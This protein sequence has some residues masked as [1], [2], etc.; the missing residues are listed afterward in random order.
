[1][2]I[3]LERLLAE[4]GHETAV[5]AMRYTE[6]IDSPWSGY[7]ASEV[8]FGGGM[9]SLVGAAMR[10]MGWGDVGA[11]FKR[12]LDDFNPDVVHLN[13]I[14]S[15]LSPVLAR[16]AHEQGAR[17]VWTLHDYKLLCPAYTCMRDGHPCEECFVDKFGVA[18]HRCMKGALP[19]SVI[20]WAE[21]VRWRR[22]VLE[23]WVD[24]F[25]C[26]SEFMR[27]KMIQ[28]GFNPD[29]LV[30]L[31]NFV[32][33][34]KLAVLERNR[35]KV[36]T[37]GRYCYVGRLSAEKGIGSLLEAAAALPY[38]LVVAGDGPQGDELRAR[39]SGCDNIDF[40]GRLDAEGVSRLLAT[41]YASVMP[42]RCYENNPLGVIESLC[43]GTPVV[44]ASIGGIPELI[45][46]D[47]GMVYKWDD[48]AQ[49]RRTIDAVMSSPWDN[50]A[51]AHDA[52]ER[53]SPAAH[54]ARLMQIYGI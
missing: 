9:K 12:L 39:Y 49:L 13:N 15:Y 42:S 4:H 1:M 5:Y 19:A 48:P 24:T 17:V 2:A 27:E 30:T 36:H 45:G 18:R 53:F 22:A 10:T 14:H 25:V 52:V 23:R 8:S 21:A 47:S 34:A 40:A 6:N 44:G 43:S 35:D 37:P 3:N 20:A 41:S 51:I 32:D 29:K 26:P 28:G 31:C 46:T 38:K 33:P 16:L 54:Y 11:S 7:F 50:A